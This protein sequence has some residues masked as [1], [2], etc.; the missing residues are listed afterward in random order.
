MTRQL[1]LISLFC[2]PA[3]AFAQSWDE[4]KL[5]ASD[6][7]TEDNYGNAVAIDG[8]WFV[9]G[10]NLKDG[11][12]DD[13]GAAYVYEYG[14]TAW[15]ET[16]LLPSD[17]AAGSE[18]GDAVAIEGNRVVVGA[19]N[20]QLTGSVYLF[21][22]DGSDWIE[23]KLTASDGATSDI[24]GTAV[25]IAGDRIFVGAEQDDDNGSNSGSVYV[26]DW[27]GTDWVETKLTASDGEAGDRFGGALAADA[28]RFVVSARLSDD[29][30]SNSGSVYVY[31]WD[32]T[33]WLETKLTASDAEAQ[34]LFGNS[35]GLSGER[36]VVG[37]HLDNENGS[38]A[39]AAYIY[40]YDGENWEETKLTASDGAI[41]NYFGHAVAVEGERIL[42]GAHF[43]SIGANEDQGAAY[44]Y[45]RDGLN[46]KEIKIS[47]TDGAEEDRFGWS[48]ALSTER[49]VVGAHEDDDAGLNAGSV[50]VLENIVTSVSEPLSESIRLYPNPSTTSTRIEWRGQ[51]SGFTYSLSDA[52]GRTLLNG[53]AHQNDVELDVSTLAAGLY[54][55]ELQSATQRHTLRL[56]RQ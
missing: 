35:V 22:Y 17:T 6:G 29:D 40:E 36:I 42:V 23:T 51:T 44:L 20:D 46:W 31:D 38:Q 18:F 3:F 27:N 8:D 19:P 9:V 15:S 55:V 24:F 34:E 16:R 14:G 11:D 54:F 30:G 45:E 7:T 56:V 53:K 49:I 32:G 43:A 4:I 41:G 26:Y 33:Q 47:A 2:L 37:K 39:G 52:L 21:E 28:D 13:T 10:A 1:L 48:V 50:Y 5:T 12:T 25:A